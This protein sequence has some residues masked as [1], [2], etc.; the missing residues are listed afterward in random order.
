MAPWEASMRRRIKELLRVGPVFR[1][2][3]ADAVGIA[4]THIKKLEVSGDIKKLSRGLYVFKDQS[5]LENHDLAVVAKDRHKLL[6][7]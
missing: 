7:P 2:R 1:S 4:R 5:D 3:D 6:F